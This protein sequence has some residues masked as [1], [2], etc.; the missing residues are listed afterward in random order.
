MTINKAIIKILK[1]VNGHILYVDGKKIEG[2]I[3]PQFN[4]GKTHKVIVEL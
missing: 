3:L 4:D 1:A 2:N